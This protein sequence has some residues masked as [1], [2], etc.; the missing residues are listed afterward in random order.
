MDFFS[1]AYARIYDAHR[2]AICDAV[3]CSTFGSQET[4]KRLT[5]YAEGL[6]KAMSILYEIEKEK[7]I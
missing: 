3:E 4:F 1:E 7:E 5:A 6:D 2:K